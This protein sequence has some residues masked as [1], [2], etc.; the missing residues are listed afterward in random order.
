[1]LL[2]G[3]GL[4]WGEILLQQSRR[5][6]LAAFAAVAATETA[7]AAAGE[8]GGWSGWWTPVCG[9]VIWGGVTGGVS[10]AYAV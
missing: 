10:A 9:R 7:G 2:E 8:M 6:S 4:F 1:M 3:W 5:K